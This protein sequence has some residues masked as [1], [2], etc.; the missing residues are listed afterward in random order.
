[1]PTGFTVRESIAARVKAL[2]L[3]ETWA[4]QAPCLTFIHAVPYLYTQTAEET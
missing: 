2:A 3:G 1:M 4:S